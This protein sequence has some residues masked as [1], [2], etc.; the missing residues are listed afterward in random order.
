MQGL[1]DGSQTV[2]SPEAFSHLTNSECAPASA[3]RVISVPG[4]EFGGAGFFVAF[5]FADHGLLR[6]R[7]VVAASVGQRRERS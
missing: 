1:V 2:A 3:V 5:D 4:F 6:R 7:L